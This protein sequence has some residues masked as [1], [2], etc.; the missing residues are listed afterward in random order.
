MA[1]YIKEHFNKKGLIIRIIL[2][3]RDLL[4]VITEFILLIK[5]LE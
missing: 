3:I 5:T 1:I 2:N 4:T